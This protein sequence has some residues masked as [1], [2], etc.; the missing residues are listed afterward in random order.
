MKKFICDCA[1]CTPGQPVK[2]THR[3]CDNKM[4]GMIKDIK[5]KAKLQSQLDKM[6]NSALADRYEVSI[7]TIEYIKRTKT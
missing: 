6:S 7:S 3:L 1:I 5:F 2:K 4:Q